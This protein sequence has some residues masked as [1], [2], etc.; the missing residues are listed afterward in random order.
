MPGTQG[1]LG[2]VGDEG[3]KMGEAKKVKNE[4]G[5]K[6]PIQESVGE[7]AA[8]S[9]RDQSSPLSLACPVRVDIE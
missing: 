6:R 2:T 4:R 5:E 3:E 1:T 9:L 7:L 8:L